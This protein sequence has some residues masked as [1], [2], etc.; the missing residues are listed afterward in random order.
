MLK[1]SG[2]D[3]TV[4]L[5]LI[6]RAAYRSVNAEVLQRRAV[7]EEI[8]R[9][10]TAIQ[11]QIGSQLFT[12]VAQRRWPRFEDL[13]DEYSQLRLRRA[14]H[15]WRTSQT[16]PVVTHDLAYPA[17]DAVL[18]QLR[19]IGLTN[20]A[21][22][23][24]KVVYYP[25]FVASSDPLFGMDY[26]QF[27]RGCHLGLFPS[28]YEPWGYAPLECVMLGIPSITSDLAGFGAF[29]QEHVPGCDELGI[30]V[31]PRRGIS[32]DAAAQDLA[33]RVEEFTRL[34]RR[35]RIALRNRVESAAEQ[36][37][38]EALYPNYTR[39]HEMALLRLAQQEAGA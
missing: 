35:E 34:E 13:V 11:E 4:V 36:F 26:D 6:T 33:E 29:V 17:D 38:W 28:L 32:F 21:E 24:V 20:A 39:A 27:V 3:R 22:D 23:R 19:Q 9:D 1:S 14:L 12:A 5:F 18:R 31:L 7:M 10:C 8:R 15:T 25:E 30:R 16:P 2:S 37:D